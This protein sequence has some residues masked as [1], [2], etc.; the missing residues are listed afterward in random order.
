M[1]TAGGSR[2]TNF[3]DL[4]PFCY[5][6]RSK[7]FLDN[8]RTAGADLVRDVKK[9][10]RGEATYTKQPAVDQ[11][12]RVREKYAPLHAADQAASDAQAAEIRRQVLERFNQQD[13]MAAF[14]NGPSPSE[15]GARV[16][17]PRE[18]GYVPVSVER[19]RLLQQREMLMNYHQQTKD[20][21]AKTDALQR[22]AQIDAQLRNVA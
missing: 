16:V 4:I 10:V 18:T 15:Q 8:L 1:G 12:A 19:T 22:L 3:I 5:M 14:L 6:E 7:S 2:S 13:E 11:Q 17:T 9:I 20:G 21:K